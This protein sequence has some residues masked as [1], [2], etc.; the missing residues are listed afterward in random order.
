MYKRVFTIILVLIV[1]ISIMV[2]NNTLASSIP[3]DWAT[4]E[5]HTAISYGLVTD[6]VTYNYQANKYNY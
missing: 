1:S 4:A 2:P 5:V 3:S 6:S